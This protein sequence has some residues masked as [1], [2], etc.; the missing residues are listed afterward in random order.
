MAGDEEV[1]CQFLVEVLTNRGFCA[2]LFVRQQP[3]AKY[4]P[5]LEVLV[6]LNVT[7]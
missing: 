2:K 6:G 4:Q 5:D 7:L 1:K 3:P